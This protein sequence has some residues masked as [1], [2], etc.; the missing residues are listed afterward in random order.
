[1][2]P[3]RAWY[4]SFGEKSFHSRLLSAVNAIYMYKD[5]Y[6]DFTSLYRHKIFK[7]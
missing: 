6:N 5:G 7:Q 4:S 2:K 1:M 3:L